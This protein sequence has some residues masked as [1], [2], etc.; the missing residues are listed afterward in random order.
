M[1]E[2]GD[3][4]A[5]LALGHADFGERVGLPPGARA[6]TGGPGRRPRGRFD[7]QEGCHC[8]EYIVP[9]GREVN[10]PRG[11]LSAA[12]VLRGVPPAPA[13]RYL[14]SCATRSSAWVT[15]DRE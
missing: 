1:P 8:R 10:G 5:L 11:D 13:R 14:H 7:G 3:A 12:F 2:L 15:P 4:H 9:A 6:G